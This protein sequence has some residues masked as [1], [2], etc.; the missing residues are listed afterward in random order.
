MPPPPYCSGIAIPT[1]PYLPA[2]ANISR[3]VSAVALPLEVV[4]DDLLG[5]PRCE[6]LPEGVVF[7]LEE[8]SHGRDATRPGV[9]VRRRPP[10]RAI[11]AARKNRN[12]AIPTHRP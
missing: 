10:A 8:R 11:A 1:K 5:D 3:G 7:V 9:C 12:T 2:E 6:R 4:R